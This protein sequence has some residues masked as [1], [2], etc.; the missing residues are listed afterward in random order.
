MRSLPLYADECWPWL[1]SKFSEYGRFERDSADY[2]AWALKRGYVPPRK[3]RAC[4]DQEPVRQP[5]LLSTESADDLT[6]C[7]AQATLS[8]PHRNRRRPNTCVRSFG[9]KAA[10][11]GAPLRSRGDC[12]RTLDHGGPLPVRQTYLSGD[13]ER[14]G[15]SLAMG[16]QHPAAGWRV[17]YLFLHSTGASFSPNRPAR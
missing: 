12:V 2:W 15:P 4:R 6:C 7:D 1:G 13:E 14:V 3:G 11:R 17:W 5:T 16:W 8:D 10:R 9:L